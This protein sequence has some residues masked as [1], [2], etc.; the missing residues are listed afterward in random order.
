MSIA[1][2]VARTFSPL[3]CVRGYR[4]Y[5]R[6]RVVLTTVTDRT[7]EAEVRGKRTQLVRLVVVDGRIGVT[8]SCAAKLL[9]PA[10]CRHVWA[11]LLEV[12]RQGLLPTLRELDRSLALVALEGPQPLRTSSGRSNAKPAK[13]NPKPAKAKPVDGTDARPPRKPSR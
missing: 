1:D 6:Q 7:I 13:P 2:R 5:A 3:A 12:D 10:A 4:Y 9:G 8:C 11:T